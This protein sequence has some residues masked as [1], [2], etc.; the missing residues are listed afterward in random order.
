MRLPWLLLWLIIP[1]ALLAAEEPA[2]ADQPDDQLYWQTQD[3]QEAGQAK[4]IGNQ[5]TLLHKSDQG[6]RLG[7]ALLLPDWQQV[8]DLLPLSRALNRQGFDTLIMLPN[9]TQLTLDPND[10]KDQ[11]AIQAF[12]E[13]WQLRLTSLQENS[14][15]ESGYQLMIAAGSSAAWLCNLLSSESIA[16]P[17]ALVLIDA[18]YPAADANEILAHDVATAP[19]PVLDLY[20]EQ[21][22]SWL[23]RAASERRLAVNRNDK[24]DWR[25]VAIRTSAE[26]EEQL[27]GW[28][29][30]LGWK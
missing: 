25:Q 30:Y 16:P 18:F 14:G 6:Y 7:L 22:V 1:S 27:T 2:P 26:R 21:Q 9:P 23:D 19:Y 11:L 12:K 15:G 10:E 24:L 17:D 28:L 3:W 4:Q 8:A 29:R 5:V 13:R 20:R